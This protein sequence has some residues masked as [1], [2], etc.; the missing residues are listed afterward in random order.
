MRSVTFFYET[1][2][3]KLIISSIEEIC[4]NIDDILPLCE[5]LDLPLV[6][7]P[8]ARGKS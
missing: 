8:N 4:Y 6:V 3:H 2:C 1:V 7:S 5:E